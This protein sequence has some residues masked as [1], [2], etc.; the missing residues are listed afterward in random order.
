MPK[1]K[2]DQSAEKPKRQRKAN[3]GSFKE[4]HAKVGGRKKGTANKVSGDTKAILA[5]VM[6]DEIQK[7]P[8]LFNQIKDPGKRIHAISE[9]LPYHM[10]KKQAISADADT[11][12]N[13]TVEEHLKDLD[14]KYAVLQTKIDV[15]SLMV[16]DFDKEDEEEDE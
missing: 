8:D 11:L 5:A 1:K 12:R 15:K 13:P 14:G 16:I 9:L 7:L 10:P 2:T 3:A 4:G 6:K